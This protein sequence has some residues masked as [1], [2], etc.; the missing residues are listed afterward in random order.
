MVGL[1]HGAELLQDT[2]FQRFAHLARSLEL[3]EEDSIVASVLPDTLRP[4]CAHFRGWKPQ[5][6]FIFEWLTCLCRL[7]FVLAL[8]G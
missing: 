3:M 4:M 6:S 1:P 7:L 5:P 2:H 8:R